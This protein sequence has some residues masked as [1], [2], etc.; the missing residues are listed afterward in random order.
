MLL[1]L[2]CDQMTPPGKLYHSCRQIRTHSKHFLF[3]LALFYLTIVQS[4]QITKQPH[5]I[6]FISILKIVHSQ[7]YQFDE[8]WIDYHTKFTYLTQ[9][10][11]AYV[12]RSQ[13]SVQLYS[14]E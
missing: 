8:M 7:T 9:A 4:F 6:I 2:I 11:V 1:D 13:P 12:E 5:S 14:L 10:V 3:D